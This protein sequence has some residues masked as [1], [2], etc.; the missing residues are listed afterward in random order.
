MVQLRGVGHEP[1]IF[2]LKRKGAAVARRAYARLGGE[3]RSRRAGARADLPSFGPTHFDS[4]RPAAVRLLRRFD[5]QMLL[6]RRSHALACRDPAYPRSDVG[7]LP[8]GDKRNTDVP[9]VNQTDRP[10]GVIFDFNGV[11]FFDSH[12]HERAWNALSTLLRGGPLTPSELRE[13]VHGRPNAYIVSY[14][15]GDA[16]TGQTATRQVEHKEEM[17]R[18]LCLR[19]PAAF[20]LSEGCADV[21][22]WLKAA[23]VPI[24]IATSSPAENVAFFREHFALER[25]FAPNTIV[26][27]DGTLP[28]K[29]APDIYLRAAERIGLRPEQC[30][31]VEDS[32]SG[33]KSARAA[34]IGWIVAVQAPQ[35]ALDIESDWI[36]A[37]IVNLRELMPVL[38]AF[39]ISK[40]PVA[41]D[42]HTERQGAAHD[43]EARDD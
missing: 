8:R 35:T 13:H 2:V 25:W 4:G 23:R 20:R 36:S 32:A 3:R 14:L 12:L 22:D 28:G 16:L 27:D 1:W 24:A 5:P 37:R 39:G 42:A 30:V 19:E 18:E 15:T 21:L 43:S 11:L 40:S 31:V 38:D 34:R 10:V 29:P 9:Q 6:S 41:G 7:L 26:H 33:I 17:Y